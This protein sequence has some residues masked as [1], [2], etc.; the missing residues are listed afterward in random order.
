[1][2][3]ASTLSFAAADSPALPEG[4]PPAKTK[5]PKLP[6]GAAFLGSWEGAPPRGPRR[7]GLAALRSEGPPDAFIPATPLY[8]QPSR[9]L[10]TN[11]KTEVTV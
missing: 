2:P 8:G 10:A 4:C 7:P 9:H 11:S 1:M 6:G 5:G 3:L